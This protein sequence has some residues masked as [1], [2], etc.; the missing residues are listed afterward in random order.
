MTQQTNENETVKIES[1]LKLS[2]RLSFMVISILASLLLS[3]TSSVPTVFAGLFTSTFVAILFDTVL[4]VVDPKASL[5]FEFDRKGLEGD[6]KIGIKLGAMTALFAIVWVGTT[7]A[8]DNHRANIENS[9]IKRLNSNLSLEVIPKTVGKVGDEEPTY[10][11]IVNALKEPPKEITDPSQMIKEN[12]MGKV[13]LLSELSEIYAVDPFDPILVKIRNEC[14]KGEGLCTFPA[15]W[16]ETKLFGLNSS[17][18]GNQVS[19]CRGHDYL[20]GKIVNFSNDN[21]SDP[22][23]TID[24]IQGGISLETKELTK[25]DKN[26]AIKVS[27]TVD[28]SCSSENQRPAFKFSKELQNLMRKSF[29]NKQVYARTVQD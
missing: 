14:K 26:T 4:F 13:N 19:V 28:R 11:Y 16:F 24:S 9:K 18:Q 5:S 29:E 6:S 8:I 23:W 21:S 10:L 22:L 17:L 15:K 20:A 1:P 2:S 27:P 25:I 3:L 12:A 7:F